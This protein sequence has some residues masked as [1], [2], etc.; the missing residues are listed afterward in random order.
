[1]Q[2]ASGGAGQ[3]VRVTGS[4]LYSANGTITAYVGGAAAP[5]SC[6]SQTSCTVTVPNLGGPRHT[7]LFIATP[8]GSSNGVAFDYT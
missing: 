4:G 2:P 1:M 8:S 3:T 7:T 5:T 6:P